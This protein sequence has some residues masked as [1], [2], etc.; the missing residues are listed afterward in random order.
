MVNSYHSGVV[1]PTGFHH[2]GVSD[3]RVRSPNPDACSPRATAHG[4]QTPKIPAQES[5][6]KGLMWPYGIPSCA[7]MMSSM[8][9]NDI[10]DSLADGFELA[11]VPE[12][13]CVRQLVPARPRLCEAGPC[14]NYHRFE[15]QVEAERPRGRKLPIL[16]PE[17]TP[18]ATRVKD[19]TL[20]QPPTPFHTQTEH[21]C[22]P[23]AGVETNLG[24]L[25][26]T[27]CN[28]WLPTEAGGPSGR[29]AIA[30]EKYLASEA[31]AQFLASVRAWE[32]QHA[33]ELA[34]AQALEQQIDEQLYG[35]RN[36]APTLIPEGDEIP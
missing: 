17:R 7:H 22:Y 3:R 36:R 4:P 10:R 9:H 23:N 20:Y 32:E 28:R 24:A 34:Q 14:A 1:D 35:S 29:V 6:R 21:Y 27:A 5:A 2:S 26:V 31:G 19:G 25:P 8:R 30:P 12:E 15:V 11:S 18:G 16:L 13:T 33:A